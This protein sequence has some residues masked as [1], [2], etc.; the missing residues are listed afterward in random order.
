MISRNLYLNILVRVIL[1]ILLSAGLGMLA[2]SGKSIRILVIGV[3]VI[4]SLAANL[5]HLLNSTN[6]K[7]RYFFDSVRDDDSTLSFSTTEKNPTVR[8]ICRNMNRVNQQIEKL[9]IDNRNQEQYFRVLIGHLPIGI[10]TYDRKGMILHSNSSASRLL[11]CEVLTHIRQT[12]RV[13]RSLYE[14]IRTITPPERRLVQLNTERGKIVLS[15][16]ATSFAGNEGDLTILSVQDIKNELDEKETESWMKLIRVL[17]HEIMNSITPIT[18]LSDTLSGIFNREGTEISPSELSK[19]EISATLNGLKVIKDQGRN[20]MSFVDSYR[21]LTRIPQPDRKLFRAADLLEHV[22]ILSSS[23]ENEGRT[24]VN[25]FLREYDLE[26]FADQSLICQVLINL[27]KNALESNAE[28]PAGMIKVEAGRGADQRPEICVTD[29]GPG[30]PAENIDEIFV[31]FFTTR[32]N[33]SGLGLSISR[34][35]MRTHGGN[36]SVS[37][38]PGEKTSFCLSF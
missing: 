26:I 33:G 31:P 34:Q 2:I 14:T 16:K 7:I 25:F 24:E 10:I 29:N 38:I 3:I 15:L 18:S 19:E 23:L 1:I 27:I 11:M 4:I 30:I 5:V 37:S 22:K 13:D 21:K 6:R 36:L 17:M 9:K 32:R 12:E 20:M 28:N 8:E 35:I